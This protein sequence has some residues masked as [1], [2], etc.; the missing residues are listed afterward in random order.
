LALALGA[1]AQVPD[2]AALKAGDMRKLVLAEAPAP[3]P[4]IAFAD[5]EGAPVSLADF[6]GKVV[7][8]N[9][10][11]TW[12]VPCRKEMPTL[13]ALQ[14]ALG[15][16]GLE[17]VAISTGPSDLAKIRRFYGEAGV[18]N[19]TVY[20]D[21]QMAVSRGMG[22]AGLPA[23]LVIDPEGREV[24]RMLGDADWNAPEA[25]ALLSALLP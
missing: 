5:A 19:L 1:N 23:T 15:P 17:V 10:W 24:G 12:C 22:V 9:F 20:I 18:D 4:L 13:D 7:V 14:Q 11:A 21:A 6:R 16:R 25:Q 8:L 2:L 3:A